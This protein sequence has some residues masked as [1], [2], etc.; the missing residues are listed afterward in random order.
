LGKTSGGGPSFFAGKD[1]GAATVKKKGKEPWLGEWGGAIGIVLGGGGRENRVNA[2]GKGFLGGEKKIGKTI[3]FSLSTKEKEKTLSQITSTEGELT[4]EESKKKIKRSQ[5]GIGR[6]RGSR[7]SLDGG[8]MEEGNHLP[9]L[10]GG[11]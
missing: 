9:E 3:R 11:G 10:Q 5:W 2:W 6:G 4:W 1:R 8:G 7:G